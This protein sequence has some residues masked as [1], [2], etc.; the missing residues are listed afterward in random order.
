MASVTD[1]TAPKSAPCSTSDPLYSTPHTLYGNPDP[2]HI[3]WIVVVCIILAIIMA[4]WVFCCISSFL[5][6]KCAS[7][8]FRLFSNR[9]ARL[10]ELIGNAITSGS[11]YALQPCSVSREEPLCS[12]L[13]QLLVWPQVVVPVAAN[14]I[15]TIVGLCIFAFIDMM[16]FY[17]R[18][19]SG[20]KQPAPTEV[21]TASMELQ[22]TPQSR[23]TGESEEQTV[24]Q[25]PS[26][27]DLEGLED[28]LALSE[29]A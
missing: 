16:I 9:G 15:L 7:S 13:P 6:R 29:K 21:A 25:S 22:S 3:R 12:G 23:P 4:D 17:S 10:G 28:V 1:T 18:R 11:M 24:L 26:A 20:E 5:D 19:T 2:P 27:E 8:R 14:M